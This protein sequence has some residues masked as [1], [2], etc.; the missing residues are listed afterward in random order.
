MR[1]HGNR[2]GWASW[3]HE[4]EKRFEQMKKSLK[5]IEIWP[6]Q[7]ISD[8]RVFEPVCKYLGLKFTPEHIV[9]NIRHRLWHG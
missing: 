5:C 9:R 6:A 2:A 7:Y 1:K 3:V 8:P 4:H